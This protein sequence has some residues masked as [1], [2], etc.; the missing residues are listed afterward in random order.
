MA[1]RVCRICA[2]RPS[3]LS[4]SRC[5]IAANASPGRATTFS[6][7]EWVTAKLDASGSG[8]AATSRSNVGLPQDTNPFGGTLRTTLRRFFGSPARFSARSFSITCSGA[9]T[10]TVPDVSNPARPARPAIWWNSRAFSSRVC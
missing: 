3:W 4:V 7:I 8:G 1:R 2:G 10:T 6:S 9:C 5:R